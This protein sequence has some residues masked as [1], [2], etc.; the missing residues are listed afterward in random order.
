LQG[1]RFV[2]S[3]SLSNHIFNIRVGARVRGVEATIAGSVE[4]DG[5]NFVLKIPGTNAVLQLSPLS[6]KVQQNVAAKQPQPAT[7]G[8]T[9]AFANLTKKF[10]RARACTVT[11]PMIQRVDGS[12]VLEVRAF[13]T[14]KAVLATTAPHGRSPFSK[15]DN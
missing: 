8:E 1:G 4:R 3:L 14:G 2:D 15:R 7:P 13:D 9:S 12:H 6:R 10:K 11:G 5:T